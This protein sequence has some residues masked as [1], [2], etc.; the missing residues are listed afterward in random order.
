MIDQ[1]QFMRMLTEL[2][3]TASVNGGQIGAGD[4]EQ[5][6]EELHLTREQ[7]APVF[8][9]LEDN[10]VRIL[11][12]GEEGSGFSARGPEAGRQTGFPE[13]ME[14]G[15]GASEE[16]ERFFRMYM[17]DLEA[18]APCTKEEMALLFP[19]ALAGELEAADRLAEG[20]L[21]RIAEWA[22]RY[23]GRGVALPDLIQEGNIMLMEEIHALGF[24]Y[25]KLDP[26]DFLYIVEKK[27]EAAMEAAIKE[28]RDQK[29]IGEKLA[30]RANR[31]MDLTEEIAEE[32]GVQPTLAELAQRL[33]ITEDEVKDIMKTSLDVI[34]LA[35]AAGDPAAFEPEES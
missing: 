26:E 30:Q 10:Q 27:S 24:Q 16:E 19:R 17:S 1:N 35:E 31:V 15:A 4:V 7:L 21:H 25:P 33:H 6:F 8:R 18:I 22:R 14:E 2:L 29:G 32:S 23:A 28:Q 3:E 9:Y 34:S 5:W 20:N 12:P 11:E 13:E